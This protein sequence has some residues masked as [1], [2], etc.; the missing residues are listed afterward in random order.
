MCGVV[1]VRVRECMCVVWGEE[2]E[3]GERETCKSLC[4]REK[5]EECGV[6]ERVSVWCVCGCVVSELCVCGVC[7]S[8]CVCVCERAR[9]C[10]CVV[11]V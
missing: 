6:C 5:E 3:R 10:V 2:R 11:C 9:E 7:E 8:E 1:F 4:V